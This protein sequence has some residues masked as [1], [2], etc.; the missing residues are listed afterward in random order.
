MRLNINRR[1]ALA[2]AGLALVAGGG[3]AYAASQGS[4][5]DPQQERQAILD[6]VA[7]RLGV[8]STALSDALKAALADRVDAAVAAGRLTQAE[9]EKLKAA[10]QSG[11][12]PFFGGF[13]VDH[14]PG[15]GHVGIELSSAAAYL[16]LTEAQLRTELESG[17][18]LAQVAKDHGK[19]VAG[20]VDELVKTEKAELDQA[21]TDGR[22]TQAQEDQIVSGLKDRITAMVQNALPKFGGRHWGPPPPPAAA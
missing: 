5:T 11:R 13:G 10:I 4:S 15:F 14:G 20:L 22:L 6:D 9:G 21:V 17:K 12:M 1:M 19:D 2:G 8:T 16:G 18:S 3:G 7:K